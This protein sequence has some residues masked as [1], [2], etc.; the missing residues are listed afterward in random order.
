MLSK[1]GWSE[2]QT[3]GKNQNGL[4]EPVNI[5]IQKNCVAIGKKHA[6]FSFILLKIP[7]KSNQSQKGLGCE[8]ATTNVT[9]DNTKQKH[10]A[11]ILEKTQKRYH[12]SE[13]AVD[14]FEAD[15]DGD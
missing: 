12:A 11:K 3:L 15:S 13:A 4:L 6:F 5:Y 7:L 8:D 9:F 1:L 2:G 10:R 14:I